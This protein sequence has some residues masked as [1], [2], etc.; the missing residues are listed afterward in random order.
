MFHTSSNILLEPKNKLFQNIND[1]YI[2][3]REMS[4]GFFIYFFLYS[5]FFIYLGV[6]FSFLLCCCCEKR[7]DRSAELF[8]ILSSDIEFACKCTIMES[9]QKG[10]CSRVVMSVRKK[11]EKR[12]EN[13]DRRDDNEEQWGETGRNGDNVC[14]WDT[15]SPLYLSN[16]NT[17]QSKRE[18]PSRHCTL[19][20]PR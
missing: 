12:E 13:E 16:L 6:S 8:Y 7:T 17:A 11:S 9:T 1:I 19:P 15:L 3:L 10:G 18:N 2:L 20:A 14:H 4:R 5:L